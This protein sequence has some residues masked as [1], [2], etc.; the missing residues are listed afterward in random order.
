MTERT[1]VSAVETVW[2]LGEHEDLT[3]GEPVAT[4]P[5]GQMSMLSVAGKSSRAEGSI[6]KD[7][8]TKAAHAVAGDPNDELDQ[9]RRLGQVSAPIGEV[10]DTRR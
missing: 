2:V 7:A 5:E 10:G 6:H 8:I 1:K 4:M 3:G 9:I